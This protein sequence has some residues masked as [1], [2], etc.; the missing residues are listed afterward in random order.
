MREPIKVSNDAI[1]PI[2]IEASK[3]Q[4]LDNAKMKVLNAGKAIN[5]IP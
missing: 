5:A 1:D 2:T 3:L 4:R